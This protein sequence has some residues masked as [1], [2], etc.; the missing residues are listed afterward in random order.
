MI[1]DVEIEMSENFL[2]D[3]V[4][5]N[6]DHGSADEETTTNLVNETAPSGTA[7]IYL[8]LFQDASF[9]R[10]KKPDKMTRV[11]SKSKLKPKKR[12]L[13]F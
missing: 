13:R 7:S 12:F 1:G 2:T 4:Q 5:L 8:V 10:G 6:V 9:W 11:K 3:M